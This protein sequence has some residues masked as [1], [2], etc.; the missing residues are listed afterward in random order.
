VKHFTDF[1]DYRHSKKVMHQGKIF[2]FPINLMTLYQ[3]YGTATPSEARRKIE[4]VRL[5]IDKPVN[6]KEWV[7]S[8]VGVTLYEMFYEGY[9]RKQWG[10]SPEDMPASIAK[11][12]PIRFNF[13]DNYFG[14][15]FRGMPVNGY[16]PMF[17]KMLSGIDVQLNTPFE[18]D[19]LSNWLLNARHVIFSGPIDEFFKYRHGALGYR[20]TDFDVQVKDVE[21]YQGVAVMNHTG[22]E[23]K[24]TKSV[25]YKHYRNR[26]LDEAKTVVVFETPRKWTMRDIP[27]YP[28]YSKS[29]SLLH[30]KYK[31]MQKE[32]GMVSF[33]GRLG[34]YKYLDMDDTIVAAFELAETHGI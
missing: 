30:D 7:T 25:E 3:V 19:D 1:N 21:D 11:R 29:N 28:I 22:M 9:T 12:I 4:E 24:Y 31:E 14:D 13:D 2:S 5:K 6:F 17:K 16:T 15:P 10:C 33:G 27:Y 20:T 32:F 26:K 23:T 18:S 34:S 8:Q